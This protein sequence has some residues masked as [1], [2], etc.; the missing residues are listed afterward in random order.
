MTNENKNV[1]Y[2]PDRRGARAQLQ[3]S[4]RAGAER[5]GEQGLGAGA[6]RSGLLRNERAGMEGSGDEREKE[7]IKC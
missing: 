2:I 1:F 5:V 4:R 7:K 6:V 3:G